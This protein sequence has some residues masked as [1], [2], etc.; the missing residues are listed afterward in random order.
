MSVW[1]ECL[2][3]LHLTRKCEPRDR[4]VNSNNR[5]NILVCNSETGLNIERNAALAHPYT[6]GNLSRAST[7]AGSAAVIREVL[8][9]CKY[10][11]ESYPVDIFHQ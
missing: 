9:L 10:K 4:Y 2:I 6:A 3:S 11:E 5:P 1:S 8:K 7:T